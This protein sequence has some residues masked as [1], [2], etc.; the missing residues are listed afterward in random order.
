MPFPLSS[1]EERGS[2]GK[3]P[4]PLSSSEERGSGGEVPRGPGGEVGFRVPAFPLIPSL[5][6]LGAIY[7]VISS[8]VVNPANALRGGG[9]IAA[10]IPVFMFW[11]RRS[12]GEGGRGK[13]EG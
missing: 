2:G 5:F 6:I 3:V 9:L 13:G 10:G 7:V 8:I 12:S 4:F 11:R 1:S